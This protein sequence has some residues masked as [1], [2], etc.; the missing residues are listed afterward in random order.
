MTVAVFTRDAAR[1]EARERLPEILD[2]IVPNFDPRKAFTCPN[3]NHEDVHPSARFLSRA[4]VVKCFSCG[5]VG[6]SF[7][8]AASAYGLDAAGAFAK[9][10]GMLNIEIGRGGKRGVRKQA[11]VPKPEPGSWAEI[12]RAIWPSGLDDSEPEI[13]LP[14]PLVVTA[15]VE[16]GLVG[17]L[18]SHRA[19]AL[20][21]V[22]AGLRAEHFD[23]REFA[24][25][26]GDIVLCDDL[27]E[28][29]G[30]FLAW[31]KNQAAP[32]HMLRRL[33]RFVVDEGRK[34]QLEAVFARAFTGFQNGES[35]DKVMTGILSAAELVLNERLDLP[36]ADDADMHDRLDMMISR[37]LAN[38]N[39]LEIVTEYRRP[40]ADNA[41]C[42]EDG[43]DGR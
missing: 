26:Y 29:P 37:W 21:C 18:L 3:P 12:V 34:R 17:I 20:V 24:E 38:E 10:Y 28:Y 25:L 2:V 23:D 5:W 35:P 16:A 41:A 19:D 6:D 27:G 32:R 11:P 33:V 8:M 1:A 43:G 39:P 36:D 31:V 7:D 42:A 15:T 14:M 13:V 9:V 22:Q 4:H 30:D 40:G